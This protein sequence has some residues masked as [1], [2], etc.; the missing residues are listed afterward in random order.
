MRSWPDDLG[1]PSDGRRV[2]ARPASRSWDG[3][4]APLP[5]RLSPRRRH[6]RASSFGAALG[7]TLLGALVP[8]SAFLVAG[9]R[10]LGAVTLGVFVLL[11]KVG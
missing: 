7:L 2:S 10:V 6:R 11:P 9:R 8:G 5:P 1:V 4:A 3:G